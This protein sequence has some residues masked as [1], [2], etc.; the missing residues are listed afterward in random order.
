VCKATTNHS[1]RRLFAF[2]HHRDVRLDAERV[3]NA[4]RVVILPDG[5]EVHMA[6]SCPIASVRGPAGLAGW[7]YP[8]AGSAG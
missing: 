4:E 3:V 6:E 8:P 5:A 7:L 2:G 1:K